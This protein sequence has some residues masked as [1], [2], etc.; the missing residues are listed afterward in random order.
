[1]RI[2]DDTSP[3]GD[4]R[5]FAVEMEL[6][7]QSGDAALR[8]QWA[9]APGRGGYGVPHALVLF[10]DGKVE[11][12]LL[13]SALA[14]FNE[15]PDDGWKWTVE[16]WPCTCFTTCAGSRWRTAAP[17]RR[18]RGVWET[19]LDVKR[20]P[21]AAGMDVQR[22]RLDMPYSMDPAFGAPICGPGARQS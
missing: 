5:A 7:D 17:R 20:F 18:A 2:L 8:E 3:G 22:G 1:M 16:G 10:E 15:P 4:S 14:R 6:G 21:L 9:S 12:S 11:P 13:R 19:P